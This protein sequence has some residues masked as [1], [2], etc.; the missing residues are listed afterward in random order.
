MQNEMIRLK[1]YRVQKQPTTTTRHQVPSTKSHSNHSHHPP[2]ELRHIKP[3]FLLRPVQNTR[4]LLQPT[5][6]IWPYILEIAIWHQLEGIVATVTQGIGQIIHH[7]VQLC[8]HYVFIISWDT[9]LVHAPNGVVQR[10][11]VVRTDSNSHVA[12]R[13]HNL[14]HHVLHCPV[15]RLIRVSFGV[16]HRIFS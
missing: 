6:Q 5:H 8:R 9:K 15:I 3:S 4:V 11:S 12:I 1:N 7:P 10:G 2:L 14:T 13:F 16:T